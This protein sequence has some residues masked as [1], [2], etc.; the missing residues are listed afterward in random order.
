MYHIY[1]SITLFMG[2]TVI[3]SIVCLALC[4]RLG[5][6]KGTTPF[7]TGELDGLVK[8]LPE[9]KRQKRLGCG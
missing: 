5:T 7:Q 8:W 2:H 6:N 1:L 3:A 4:Q 9:V